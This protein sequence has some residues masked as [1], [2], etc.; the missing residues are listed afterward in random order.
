MNQN[1]TALLEIYGAV[2]NALEKESIPFY[3][4]YGTALGAVRH[5]G[6]IPWDDDI[7]IAVF[8]EDLPRVDLALSELDS[9]RYYYHIPSADTHPHV[10][11]KT[12]DFESDLKDRKAP[13]I[14][15]FIIER[16]P[17]KPIRAGLSRINVRLF[18]LSMS[19]TYIPDSAIGQRLVRWIPKLVKRINKL[20]VNRDS[21]ET[22]MYEEDYR[23]T[24]HSRDAYGTPVMH[25]FEDTEIPLPEKWETMLTDMY[26]D[27][28]TPPPEDERSGASGYP[29]RAYQDYIRDRA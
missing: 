29:H 20:L 22:V 7:D 17:S 10:F 16:S 23:K 15:I 5:D 27:Y 24:F 2:K 8:E 1:Q 3:A 12:E 28:M 19:L 25:P 4:C 21:R 6:L 14:D 26:G 13:F 9:E 11:L 18:M